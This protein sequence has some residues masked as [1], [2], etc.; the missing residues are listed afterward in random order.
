MRL[1]FLAVAAAIAASPAIAQQTQINT[2]AKGQ[3]PMAAGQVIINLDAESMKRVCLVPDSQGN[4]TLLYSNGA[5]ICMNGR[6]TR[7]VNGAWTLDIY[8]TS[9][10]LR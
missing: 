6:T 9:A 8:D 10:C 4:A 5:V 1:L 7:C 2:F 3:Q